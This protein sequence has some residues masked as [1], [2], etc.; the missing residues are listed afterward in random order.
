MGLNRLK[1]IFAAKPVD[2]RGDFLTHAPKTS[3]SRSLL[4]SLSVSLALYV[5]LS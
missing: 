4:L 2:S 5:Y 3:L 1:G